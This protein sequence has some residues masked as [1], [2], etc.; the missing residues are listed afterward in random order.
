MARVRDVFL[1]CFHYAY[2]DDGVT[3]HADAITRA[4]YARGIDDCYV[5]GRRLCLSAWFCVLR[6]DAPAKR[7]GTPPVVCL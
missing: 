2:A 4:L 3:A 5:Y 6:E 7:R 1:L